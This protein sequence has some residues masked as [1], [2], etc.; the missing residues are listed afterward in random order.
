MVRAS[1]PQEAAAG[2]QP[3]A[4]PLR[5]GRPHHNA[6]ALLHGIRND[7]VCSPGSEAG[8]RSTIGVVA[9][10]QIHPRTTTPMV[11][12]WDAG[13]SKRPRRPEMREPPG[14]ASAT[15]PPSSVRSQRQSTATSHRGVIPALDGWVAGHECPAYNSETLYA[16]GCLFRQPDT[17]AALRQL[18]ATERAP[19]LGLDGRLPPW[20]S[21]RAPCPRAR[22]WPRP[23]DRPPCPED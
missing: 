12:R 4:F 15:A 9:A 5:A 10:L 23:R 22:A 6:A 3:S 1:R 20:W 16:T 11:R 21:P 8:R 19:H 14:T 2:H 18:P 17:S 7:E 13:A